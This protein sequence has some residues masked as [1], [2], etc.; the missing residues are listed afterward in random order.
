MSLLYVGRQP[1]HGSNSDELLYMVCDGRLQLDVGG[2]DAAHVVK[3]ITL[4]LQK[5][6]QSR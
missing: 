4:L 5:S 2:Q 6:P 3:L 1:F